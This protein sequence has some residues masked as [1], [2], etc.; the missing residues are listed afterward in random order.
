MSSWRS[1]FLRQSLGPKGPQFRG[2]RERFPLTLLWRWKYIFLSFFSFLKAFWNPNLKRAPR[3]GFVPWPLRPLSPC[4]PWAE[5]WV[6]NNRKCLQ[7]KRFQNSTY[8]SAFS[9]NLPGDSWLLFGLLSHF[10]EML[11]VLKPMCA[12]CVCA[13]GSDLNDVAAVSGNWKLSGVVFSL[14]YP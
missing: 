5:A 8:L 7:D 11:A 12:G 6:N 10:Q 13:V 9:K 2:G 14:S 1:V 3:V 4:S